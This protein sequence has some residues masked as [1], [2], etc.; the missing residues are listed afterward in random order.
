MQELT[1][2]MSIILWREL[3]GVVEFEHS[4]IVSPALGGQSECR[5]CRQTAA[6]ICDG[7]QCDPDPFPGS[8]ADIAEE[9][10]VWIL[11]ADNETAKDYILLVAQQCSE[12][13]NISAPI[14][15]AWLTAH[16]TPIDKIKAFTELLTTHETGKKGVEE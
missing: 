9:I 4:D 10:R 15:A 5:K 13:G 12:F 3:R 11:K 16:C 8:L 7:C 14:L 1:R 2:E 6:E